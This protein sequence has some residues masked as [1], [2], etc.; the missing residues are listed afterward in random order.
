MFVNRAIAELA[1]L[2][3]ASHNGPSTPGAVARHTTLKPRSTDEVGV[4]SA[5]E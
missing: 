5:A 2:T 3:A 4:V 1:L